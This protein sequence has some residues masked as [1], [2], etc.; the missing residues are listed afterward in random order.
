MKI[1]KC[2]DLDACGFIDF[3]VTTQNTFIKAKLVTKDIGDGNRN[4][5]CFY[6][7]IFG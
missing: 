2:L 7:H 6:K 4:K 3:D 5:R 1:Y